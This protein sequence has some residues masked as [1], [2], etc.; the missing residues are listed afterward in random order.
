MGGA[1]TPGG[2]VGGEGHKP[3][4][5]GAGN[6]GNW[7]ATG[8]GWGHTPGGCA[9]GCVASA[10]VMTPVI[11]TFCEGIGISFQSANC[12]EYTM[13]S[14]Q[15]KL[16][17][18]H[19]SREARATS[20]LLWTVTSTCKV[21]HLVRRKETLCPEPRPLTPTRPPANAKPPSS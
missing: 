12:P 16:P 7:P 14:Q 18:A 3:G 21:P 19:T 1:T 11:T 20:V 6:T 2:C 17:T 5:C 9:G 13:L 15:D 4:G 10:Q 8:G